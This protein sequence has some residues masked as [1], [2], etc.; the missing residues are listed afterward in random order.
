LAFLLAALACI[1][2]FAALF[3]VRYFGEKGGVSQV[4]SLTK[5]VSLGSGNFI[6]FYNAAITP[7]DKV[8]QTCPLIAWT[9]TRYANLLEHQVWLWPVENPLF[10]YDENSKSRILMWALLVAGIILPMLSNYLWK[11]EK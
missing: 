1:G 5:S 7:K 4:F 10:A 3:S 9:P 8:A 11:I 2:A 6:G